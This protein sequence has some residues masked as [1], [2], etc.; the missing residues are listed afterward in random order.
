MDS[1]RRPCPPVFTALLVLF[2]AD[3]GSTVDPPYYQRQTTWNDTLVVSLE[4][5][6]ELGLEESF[7]SFESATLRGGE[8]ARR[9][10]V[11][12]SGAREMYLFVSGSPDKVWGVAD[13]ADGKLIAAGGVETSLI[14]FEGLEV[15]KG[16]HAVDINLHSGLYE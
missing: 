11:D 14:H 5:L 13:W 3:R 10:S 15:L 7:L 1:S 8:P 6:E 9:V 2:L 4:A 16:R 12:I